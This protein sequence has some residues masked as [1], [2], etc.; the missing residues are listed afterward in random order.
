MS[1]FS[2]LDDLAPPTPAA[3]SR[4]SITEAER[5]AIDAAIAAG[6]VNRVPAGVAAGLSQ[7]ET[8]LFAAPPP[9]KYD[10]A[11]LSAARKRGAANHAR[12]LTARGKR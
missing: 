4:A 6:R 5:A 2:R 11:A 8:K 9:S 7:L 12:F 1:F 10:L 3:P